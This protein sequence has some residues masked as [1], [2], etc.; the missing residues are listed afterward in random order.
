M[1]N[2][3]RVIHPIE[4]YNNWIGGEFKSSVINTLQPNEIVHYNREIRRKGENWLEIYIENNKKAY[5]KVSRVHYELYLY[6]SLSD[7]NSSG[8]SFDIIDKEVPFGSI[9]TFLSNTQKPTTTSNFVELK[10]MF[11][12]KQQVIYLG[13]NPD[14]VSVEPIKFLKNQTFFVIPHKYK[15]DSPFI[16]VDNFKGK[17]G[18][19]LKTTNYMV[20]SETWIFNL[21]IFLG[22][23]A[24]I[25]IIGY[26]LYQG[27]FV[28]NGLAAI[29]IIVVVMFASMIVLFLAKAI[30]LGIFN[31]IRK[32]F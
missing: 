28:F 15:S 23:S 26:I 19:L 22:V 11:D 7:E 13:Y 9:F 2:Y 25:S 17:K 16:E 14:I 10:R 8:F 5:I 30:I 27:Y 12:D 6:V 21:S 3:L 18:L 4:V 29:V 31:Q 24:V 20:K 32:R 1:D